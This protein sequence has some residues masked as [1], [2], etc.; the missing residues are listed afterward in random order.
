MNR[1]GFVGIS[2]AALFGV[3]GRAFSKKTERL[4]RIGVLV[5][6]TPPHPFADAFRRGLQP[7]GYIEGENLAIEWRYTEGKKVIA[8]PYSRAS[9]FS[10]T[11]M[12]S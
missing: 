11:S 4:P 5:S 2:I 1:R 8:S 3:P 9:W 10:S 6:A 7:L 12:S